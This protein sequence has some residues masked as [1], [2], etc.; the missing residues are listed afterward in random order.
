MAN[1]PKSSCDVPIYNNFLYSANCGTNKT[2]PV[3][4]NVTMNVKQKFSV[5]SWEKVLFSFSLSPLHLAIS[6]TPRV[7]R[8]ILHD[9]LHEVAY[10]YIRHSQY[11]SHVWISDKLKDI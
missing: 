8:K 5:N 2:A 11:A 1:V 3:Y 6:L 9:T 4:S 7:D 10:P